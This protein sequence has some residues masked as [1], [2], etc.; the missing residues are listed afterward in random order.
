MKRA[1]IVAA[2]FLLAYALTE[3]GLAL[4]FHYATDGRETGVYALNGPGKDGYLFRPH[5]RYNNEENGHQVFLYNNL[6]LPGTDVLVAPASA[7]VFVLGSSTLLAQQVPPPLT[8]TAIFHDKAAALNRGFQVLN[9]GENGNDPYQSWFRAQYF[10]RGLPPAYVILLLENGSI[11]YLNKRYRGELDFSPPEKFGSFIRPGPI[12][13]ITRFLRA[14]SPLM[15]LFL[16]YA[17]HRIRG[18]DPNLE[19]G[20]SGSQR[21]STDDIPAR[22][23]ACLARF[24]ASFGRRF[25]LLSIM[26][27]QPNN[28]RL[29]RFCRDSGIPFRAS[30]AIEVPTYRIRGFGHLTEA[31]NRNLGEFLYESFAAFVR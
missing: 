25:L 11:V 28:D 8:A 13:R 22:L 16:Y 27:S 23:Y 15:N 7:Y 1:V 6:G 30:A 2:A 4:V 20:E 5:S 18:D 31:G 24:R 19:E 21:A 9:L 12:K 29:A 10:K 3:I 17:F 26:T 14:H